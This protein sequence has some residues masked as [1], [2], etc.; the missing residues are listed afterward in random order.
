MTDG[1][2]PPAHACSD[3]AYKMNICVIDVYTENVRSIIMTFFSC[4]LFGQ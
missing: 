1:F 2:V 4:S 3:E